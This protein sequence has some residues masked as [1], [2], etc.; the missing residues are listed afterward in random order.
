MP[1][2]K[3]T[4]VVEVMSDMVSRTTNRFQALASAAGPSEESREPPQP[5]PVDPGEGTSAGPVAALARTPIVP[6][7]HIGEAQQ[8]SQDWADAV[9]A[10]NGLPMPLQEMTDTGVHFKM[11]PKGTWRTTGGSAKLRKNLSLSFSLDTQ[12]TSADILEGLER[13]GVIIASISAIQRRASTKSWVVTFDSVP[14]KELA[15]S[16]ARFEVCGI[17]VF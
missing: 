1:H 9:E 12:C 4:Q 5:V 10:F 14:M 13:V 8:P 2:T 16:H 11:S 6:A 3:S 7:D 15:L 17:P